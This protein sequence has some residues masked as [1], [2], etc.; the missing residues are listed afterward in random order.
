[1]IFFQDKKQKHAFCVSLIKKK[2]A[3][4]NKNKIWIK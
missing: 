4:C 3:K 2:R 1:M